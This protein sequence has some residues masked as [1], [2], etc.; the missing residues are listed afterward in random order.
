M[1]LDDPNAA[2][3]WTA[4]VITG[5]DLAAAVRILSALPVARE[6]TESSVR[7]AK[8]GSTLAGLLLV[9]GDPRATTNPLALQRWLNPVNAAAAAALVQGAFS[10]TR[11]LRQP[12]PTPQPLTAWHALDPEIVYSRLSSR[13]R[14]LAVEPGI[15]PLATRSGGPV[16]QPGAGAAAGAGGS[17]G[18]LLSATRAELADPLTPILAVGAAASAIVGSNI[19]ALLVAGVM[20]ANAIVGGMQRLRAEAAVAELFAEQD[21]LARRVVLPD[22]GDVATPAGRGPQRAANGHG[23]R[24]VAAPGRRHRPGR[25]RGGTGGCAPAGGRGPRSRRVL[26]HR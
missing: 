4:D 26:P 20:T 17:N 7:L 3:P 16:L 18:R 13:T 9:T 23:Q 21:Q 15:A 6:A 19:D 24:Q 10:A 1:A 22:D 8:G 11:V 5:T 12:V 2:T 14:P 25:T